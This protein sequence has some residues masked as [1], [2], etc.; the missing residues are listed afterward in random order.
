MPDRARVGRRGRRRRAAARPVPLAANLGAAVNLAVASVPE[1]LPF[2][3][4]AAQLAAARRLSGLGALVRNPRTIEA[5]GRVDV[6]CFDKT[7]TLTEG[8]TSSSRAVATAAAR[9]LRPADAPLGVLAAGLRAT[10]PARRCRPMAHQ[11][12][13]RGDVGAPTGRGRCG[14]ERSRWRRTDALPFEPT[15][16]YHATP[17]APGTVRCSA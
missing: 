13:P 11:Y 6:L 14:A 4:N 10:P 17:G 3:V 2:L 12:R 8:R 7:G 1:G 9:S 16:A 15:R 5:L